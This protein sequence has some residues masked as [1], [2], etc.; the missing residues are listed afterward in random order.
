MIFEFYLPKLILYCFLAFL[1]GFVF[2]YTT[3]IQSEHKDGKFDF[4]YIFKKLN[5]P[6]LFESFWKG[7]VSL[8]AFLTGIKLEKFDK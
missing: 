4:F 3:I 6:E 8:I 1:F 7:L 2:I 5:L